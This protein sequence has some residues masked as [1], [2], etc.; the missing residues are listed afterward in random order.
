MRIDPRVEEPTRDLFGHA[1]RAE[2]KDF[3]AVLGRFPDDD[4]LRQAL[5]LA[6]A[7]CAYVVV[8]DYESSEPAD[9]DLRDAADTVSDIEDRYEI[10]PDK[11]YAY[12][13]RCVFGGEPVTAVLSTD[14][15]ARLP[16]IIGANLV[17]STTDT[18]AGQK[19]S[20]RLDEVEAALEAA[21]EPS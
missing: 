6:G 8:D 4:S 9:D 15:A 20:D 14:D 13:R 7:I 5:G 11:V 18:D 19:W 2:F 21:P 3:E 17:G 1:L 16:F 12:L 10:D